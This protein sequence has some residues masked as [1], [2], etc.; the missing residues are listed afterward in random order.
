MIL[1]WMIL[2]K[3][4]G[5]QRGRCT[6]IFLAIKMFFVKSLS[7]LQIDWLTSYNRQL[8]GWSRECEGCRLPCIHLWIFSG[9][10]TI[11]PKIFLVQATGLGNVFEEK[12]LEINGRSAYKQSA[13]GSGG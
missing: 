12:C 11:W 9:S 1:A 7:N 2:L 3:P 4:P 5:Q 10:I 8:N 13:F 6:F